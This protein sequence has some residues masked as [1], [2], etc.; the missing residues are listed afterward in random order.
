MPKQKLK[1][2]PKVA[3]R[4]SGEGG[5]GLQCGPPAAKSDKEA[6]KPGA[7]KSSNGAWSSVQWSR[8][9]ARSRS[10]RRSDKSSNRREM[11]GV[12]KKKEKLQVGRHVEF[13][14]LVR[15][16]TIIVAS[17]LAAHLRWFEAVR[18]RNSFADLR[19]DSNASSCMSEDIGEVEVAAELGAKKKNGRRPKNRASGLGCGIRM[20]TP[21]TVPMT[22]TPSQVSLRLSLRSV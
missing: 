22:G 18:G 5:Y 9:G 6:Q 21:G 17:G 2:V 4:S 1:V 13:Q 16:F 3:W 8:R 12:I 7:G 10:P 11:I 19:S 20:K 15:Q 14:T